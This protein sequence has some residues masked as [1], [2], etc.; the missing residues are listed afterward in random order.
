MDPGEFWK[1]E[2]P[3][4]HKIKW[5]DYPCC[6][7]ENQD[8]IVIFFHDSILAKIAAL[9]TASEMLLSSPVFIVQLCRSNIVIFNPWSRP[10][11]IAIAELGF[12]HLLG[13]WQNGAISTFGK[14]YF[15]FS[16]SGGTEFKFTFNGHLFPFRTV[17]KFKLYVQ[18]GTLQF[19]YYEKLRERVQHGILSTY[20]TSREVLLLSTLSLLSLE[21]TN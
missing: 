18:T 14:K 3:Y 17:H 13:H 1:L 9:C 19:L 10:Y 7:Y 15:F 20:S 4:L 6:K 21:S 8:S 5:L 11:W 16:F 2:L 12:H